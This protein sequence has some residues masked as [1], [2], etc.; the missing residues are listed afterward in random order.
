MVAVWAALSLGCGSDA[1]AAERPAAPAASQMA[2]RPVHDA[3][4]RTY[5]PRLRA[6]GVE[7]VEKAEGED[8]IVAVHPLPGAHHLLQ[9]GEIL[10]VACTGD[11]LY[12]ISISAPGRPRTVARVPLRMDAAGLERRGSSLI[13]RLA[14]GGMVAVDISAPESLRILTPK[15]PAEQRTGRPGQALLTTGAV[16]LPAS[17]LPLAL[18]IVGFAIPEP[19]GS[20][21]WCGL[22]R[23]AGGVGIAIGGGMV[24]SGIVLLIV[25]LDKRAAGIRSV[26]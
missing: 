17:V 21:L 23:V 1:L 20:C 19:P 16:L 24:L 22:G 14:D 18:G 5:A 3:A 25:G 7:I 12:A 8:R 4:T 10:Y 2:E 26:R 9:V 11:G 13:V 6:E 15:V